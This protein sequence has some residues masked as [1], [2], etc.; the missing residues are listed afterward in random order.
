MLGDRISA[1][2]CPHWIFLLHHFRRRRKLSGGSR[3]PLRDKA[4]APAKRRCIARGAANPPSIPGSAGLHYCRKKSDIF[5]KIF[6]QEITKPGVFSFLEFLSS[7]FTRFW[8]RLPRAAQTFWW[9]ARSIARKGARTCETSLYRPR[10]GRSTYDRGFDLL[11]NIRTKL[12]P[13][14]ARRVKRACF[15]SRNCSMPEAALRPKRKAQTVTTNNNVIP[16]KIPYCSIV[17]PDPLLSRRFV[18]ARRGSLWPQPGA[19][20]RRPKLKQRDRSSIEQKYQQKNRDEAL[21]IRLIFLIRPP[22]G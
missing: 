9:I 21:T 2:S 16:I 3:T 4:D 18:L 12:R 10:S 13:F 7:K 20:S 17:H 11:T 8:F 6:E 14:G 15:P 5:A 22:S 19:M 1:R